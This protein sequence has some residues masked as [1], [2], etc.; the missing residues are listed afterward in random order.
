MKILNVFD[1]VE[2]HICSAPM[3]FITNGLPPLKGRTMSDKMIYM[4][5]HYDWIRKR[6]WNE[7]GGKRAL[8]GGFLVPPCNPEANFGVI[9]VDGEK[10]EPM[11]GGGSLSLAHTVVSLGMVEPREPVTKILFDTPAGLVTTYVE[12]ENGEI[13]KVTLENIPSFLYAKD[14]M[15]EIEGFGKV[16]L[17]VGFGGNFFCLVDV[18]QLGFEIK[19]ENRELIGVTA[20]KIIAAANEIIS[21]QHPPDPNLNFLDQCLFCQEPKDGSRE[22]TAQ[23]VYGDRHLDDCPC[24]TGTSARMAR[25]YARGRLGLNEEFIQKNNINRTP[26]YFIGELKG[27]TRVGELDAVLPTLSAT[28]AAVTSFGKLIV[29]EEDHYKAG[30]ADN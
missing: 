15:V 2:S 7:A 9:W 11:C 19:P 16:T 12:I 20:M 5:E 1:Y 17:D 8:C 24:G 21:V 22:Y 4:R 26:K 14:L 25:M 6:T 13:K 27:I 29:T 3:R 28:D 10:Y 30:F 23:C 18:E